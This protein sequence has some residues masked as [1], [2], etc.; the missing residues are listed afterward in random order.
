MSAPT[1]PIITDRPDSRNSTLIFYWNSPLSDGDGSGISSYT[2]HC[3]NPS[4][5]IQSY[6]VQLG[7]SALITG[8]TNRN[9]YFFD[10]YCTNS[11]GIS[12]SAVSF[13]AKQP[14]NPPN[15]PVFSVN[16]NNALSNLTV[17]W[18][19][20]TNDGGADIYRYGIWV[21]PAIGSNLLS[22]FSS[23]SSKSYT[24]SNVFSRVIGLPNL[25]SNYA[26]S[27]H[28]INDAGWSSDPFDSRAYQFPAAFIPGVRWN[29]LPIGTYQ[30]D[31]IYLFNTVSSASTA[32]TFDG[33]NIG[34]LTNNFRPVGAFDQYCTEWTGY[35]FAQNTGNHTF[36][37]ESDDWSF[38][39][40]GS[41]AQRGNYN[42]GNAVVNNGGSHG[43]L[44]R[45]G[46]ISLTAGIYYFI[47]FSHGDG[48]G[49][50]DMR[51]SFSTPA[52][53]RTYNLSNYLFHKVG[54]PLI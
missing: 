45:S 36:W 21:F 53:G 29:A 39:W 18:S 26:V 9:R 43:V 1:P 54:D 40:I 8:L 7:N 28:A 34:T 25:S 23:L 16:L 35:F 2:L 6:P 19:T 46:T 31:G 38:V 30:V 37:T 33:T 3:T 52:Q 42:T 47:R 44:E 17:N 51:F 15:P 50:D 11:N 13:F 48:G 49:G 4:T 5:I 10:L 14:G 41:N 22:N 27:V 20:P 24:Y 32:V 12:S